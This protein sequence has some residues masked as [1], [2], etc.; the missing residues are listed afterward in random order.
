[1]KVVKT[2]QLTTMP[3]LNPY[4]ISWVRKGIEIVVTEMYKIAFTIGKQYNCKVLC[5]V[6][7]MDVC[8]II[9]DRP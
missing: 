8:H 2:L 4:K 6:I 1:M 7:D 9:L 3:H 5:D